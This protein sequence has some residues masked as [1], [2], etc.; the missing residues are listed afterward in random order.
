[1]D[2]AVGG[3]GVNLE[4]IIR[5]IVDVTFPTVDLD[6]ASSVDE[7]IGATE[8]IAIVT[9]GLKPDVDDEVNTAVDTVVDVEVIFAVVFAA[10]ET[11]TGSA[12]VTLTEDVDK[13]DDSD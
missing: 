3:P 9:E 8:V 2:L 12:V 5:G 13:D 4:V 1:V 10:T 6:V 11:T 7:D